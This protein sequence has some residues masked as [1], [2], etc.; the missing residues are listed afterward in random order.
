[1]SS[2]F[3]GLTV[4][5]NS[6]QT[7]ASW[8]NTIRTAGIALETIV[9]GIT[10]GGGGTE[11]TQVVLNNQSATAVT[12]LALSSLYKKHI[13]DYWVKRISTSGGGVTVMES[14]QYTALYDGTTWTIGRSGAQI[15][16]ANFSL[17]IDSSTGVVDYVTDNQ[18][19]TYDTVNSKIGYTLTTRGS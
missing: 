15:G 13:I 11:Q 1:M 18:A 17:T 9:N 5:Q 2:F 8:W 3:T 19:G 7:D 6:T 10:G 14:G 4:R 12:G 16:L